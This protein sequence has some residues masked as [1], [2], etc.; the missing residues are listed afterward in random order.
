VRP[1]E[2][3]PA[4]LPSLDGLDGLDEGELENL[5][6]D[7]L[8]RS[9]LLPS[10]TRTEMRARMRVF[11]ANTR[12]Y[13][14][15]RPRPFSGRTVLIRAAGTVETDDSAAWRAVA[16][17]LEVVTVPGDHYTLLQV[18]HLD[19][20]TAALRDSLHGEQKEGS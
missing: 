3:D 6:L 7:L 8:D 18:P 1:P 4:R 17:R 10:G 13:V 19:A 2:A 5:A 20:L 14:S 15:H 11:A 16:P 12:A 9:G